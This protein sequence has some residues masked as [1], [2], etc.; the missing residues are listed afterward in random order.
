MRPLDYEI[1]IDEASKAINTLLAKEIDNN[2]P[3]FGTYDVVRSKVD[4]NLKT[5]STLK[6]KD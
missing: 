6:K 5:V 4:M 2:A 1:N 3:L